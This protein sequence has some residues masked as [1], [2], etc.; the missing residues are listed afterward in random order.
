MTAWN[1][2]FIILGI[3]IVIGIIRLCIKKPSTF[4]DAIMEVLCI[5]V[6]GELLGSIFEH[7][8]FD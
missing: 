8:D 1:I 3:I 2:F 7:I 5:D 4:G 6:L